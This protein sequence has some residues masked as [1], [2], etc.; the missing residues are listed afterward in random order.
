[1]LGQNVPRLKFFT[2]LL[3]DKAPLAP[4]ASYYQRLLAKDEVEAEQVAVEYVKAE[5]ANK[6]YD[7][8]LLPALILA[9]RDRKKSGLSAESEGLVF[10]A[11]KKVIARLETLPTTEEQAPGVAVTPT[12]EVPPAQLPPAPAPPA[13]L[14]FG[15]PAHH[16]AEELAL[17]MLAALLKPDGCRVEALSTKALPADVEARIE[18]EQPALVFIATLPPGGLVQ[19]RYLCKRLHRRFPDL[20]IIVGYWG[21]TRDFD[22]LLIRFRSVGAAYVTTSLLQSRSQILAL[23]NLPALSPPAPAAGHEFAEAAN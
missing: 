11:T 23:M 17:D 12:T 8:V 20:P 16:Q 3:G 9:R 1:V 18:Q 6:V 14:I 2:L 7:D 10:E 5:G 19:A 21:T 15:C 4:H 22:R 13:I